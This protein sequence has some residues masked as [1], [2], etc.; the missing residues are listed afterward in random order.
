MISAA[1]AKSH[2]GVTSVIARGKADV[3]LGNEKALNR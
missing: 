1:E 3:G 2:L